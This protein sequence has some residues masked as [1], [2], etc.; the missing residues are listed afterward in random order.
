MALTGKVECKKYP[1]EVCNS[2]KK[3]QQMQIRKLH[4]QQVIK[5]TAKQ[6]IADARIATLVAKLRISS[7][8]RKVMSRKLRER[9]LKNQHG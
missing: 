4:E 5:H 9:L 7:Q 8:P 2:M 3:E 1:K 6:T